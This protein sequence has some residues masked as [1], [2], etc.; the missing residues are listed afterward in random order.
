MEYLKKLE[1]HRLHIFLVVRHE[2]LGELWILQATVSDKPISQSF[3]RPD[4]VHKNGKPTF[5]R[6]VL[7]QIV[8][9]KAVT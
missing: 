8:A 9:Y 3:L 6:H 5:E 4:T 2:K 1:Q 7:K